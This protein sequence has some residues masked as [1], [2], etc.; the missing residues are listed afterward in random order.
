MHKIFALRV[1]RSHFRPRVCQVVHPALPRR[2]AASTLS[3]IQHMFGRDGMLSQ[4]TF[5]DAMLLAKRH[6]EAHAEE[7]GYT[8]SEASEYD[9]RIDIIRGKTRAP[10]YVTSPGKRECAP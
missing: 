1:L 9:M 6:I 2:L 7:M 4:A 8:H 10:S 3:E 5:I